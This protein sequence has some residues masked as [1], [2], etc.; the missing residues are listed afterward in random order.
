[1]Q[2]HRGGAILPFPPRHAISR[3]EFF[4]SLATG[5]NIEERDYFE[6]YLE[7]AIVFARSALL[8]LEALYKTHLGW[9]SWWDSLLTDPDVNF[10]RHERNCIIHKAPSKIG[11]IISVGGRS[12]AAADYYYYEAPSIPAT[13]TVER[14][15]KGIEKIAL[16]SEARFT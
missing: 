4:L 11:Q 14:H 12:N 9:K 8:R 16:D 10:F 15:L 1:M 5:C 2:L 13:A 3:A 7:A 6:A